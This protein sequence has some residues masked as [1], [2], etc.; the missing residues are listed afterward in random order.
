ML[1]GNSCISID[2]LSTLIQNVPKLRHGLVKSDIFPQDRQ[3]FS[4][5]VKICSGGV[6]NNLTNVPNSEGII[7]Y[8][9][10]L[11]SII[12]AYN[13]KETTPI[14]RLYHAWF[15]VFVSRWWYTWI[16]NM[17]KVDLDDILYE[18]S[19]IKNNR[20]NKKHQFFITNNAYYCIEINANQLMYLALLVTEKKLPPEAMNVYLFSSQ[21]CEGIFRSACSISGTFSSVVN[22]T[23]QEF[24]NRAQKLSLLNKI[25]TE[26]EFF[27]MNGT[28][29]FPKHYKQGK[30]LKKHNIISNHNTLNVDI[31]SNTILQAFND[32]TNLIHGFKIKNF[33]DEKKITNMKQLNSYIHNI[34]TQ[35]INIMDYSDLYEEKDETSDSEDELDIVLNSENN[36]ESEDQQYETSC[37][38]SNEILNGLDGIKFSG[39]RVF[40]TV[41]PELAK[42]FFEV[43]IG[44]K[45]K[46]VHKQTACWIFTENKPVLLNDRLTRVM[47]K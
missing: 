42:S 29:V 9:R 40:D 11:R 12:I 1:I 28:L 36:A 38:S 5:C 24:F 18:L 25:K 37:I 39:M 31:I 3:N 26:S 34:L 33:L 2:Y 13:D 27:S 35:R 7:L 22:F 46:F 32:A 19:G 43:E 15:P 45:T 23:V 20:K 44:G 16:A 4:S 6:I 41:R 14:H 17:R 47:Q 8:L 10:L 21:T 30:K